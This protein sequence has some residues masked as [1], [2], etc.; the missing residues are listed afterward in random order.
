MFKHMGQWRNFSFKPPQAFSRRHEYS[1]GKGAGRLVRKAIQ[2][3]SELTVTLVSWL[4]T[5]CVPG[6]ALSPTPVFTHSIYSEAPGGSTIN[7]LILQMKPLRTG[8]I[9]CPQSV[10]QN[11]GMNT[12]LIP[13]PRVQ[14]SSSHPHHP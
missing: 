5:L 8:V 4:L 10:G 2:S 13:D 6:M 14:P 9:E 1:F 12:T 11:Q 7:I 3:L